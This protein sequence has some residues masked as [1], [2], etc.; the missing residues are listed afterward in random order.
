MAINI[1]SDTYDLD[2]AEQ[3]TTLCIEKCCSFCENSTFHRDVWKITFFAMY[4]AAHNSYTSLDSDF[5]GPQNKRSCSSI[6][7]RDI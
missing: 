4:S 5:V 2:L 1:A 7:F 6:I 3:K